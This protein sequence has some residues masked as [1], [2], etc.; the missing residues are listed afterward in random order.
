MSTAEEENQKLL[1]EY[2]FGVEGLEE[3]SQG[4]KP[5]SNEFYEDLAKSYGWNPDGKKSAEEYI[6]FALDKFPKRGDALSAQNKKIEAKDSELS[7]M[8]MVLDQLANDMKKS[9]EV[10]Y[11]QAL[12][13][14]QAQ[15]REAISLGDVERVEQI[16]KETNNLNGVQQPPEVVQEFKARNAEWLEGVNPQDL[17]MQAY[18]HQID[19]ALM[20]KRLPPEQHMKKLDEAMRAKFKAYFNEDVDGDYKTSS[21]SVEGVQQENNILSHK[22]EKTFTFKD[23]DPAQKAA[24]KYLV[25]KG[26]MTVETYI[27]RLVEN[28]DLK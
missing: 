11:Q 20:S 14:L 3:K 19:N 2:E 28:G 25:E 1:E 26:Q 16:E 9:K 22:K 10:A 21:Y 18:A 23:L 24:A 17:E 8:K 15:K 12:A 4:K 7:Q 6:K 5:E 27:K 13:D